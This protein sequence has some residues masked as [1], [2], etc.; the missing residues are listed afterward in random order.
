MDEPTPAIVRVHPCGSEPMPLHSVASSRAIERQGQASLPPHTLMRRAGEAV[1]RLALAV[2]PHAGTIWI[3]A[4]PGNNGGDG[5]EAARMLHLAGKRVAVS[6][7]ADPKQLP[8]DASDAL[9]RTQ[10]VGVPI[11]DGLPTRQEEALA[12]DALL[13]LGMRRP[14]EGVIAEAIA[15]LNAHQRPVL[16]VDVPSGLDCERGQPL[17]GLAVEADHTL[18]LL[19]LKPG[20]FTAQGRDHAGAVWLCDLGLNTAHTADAWLSAA[21]SWRQVAQVRRHA[22]HKGSF[23]DVVVIGGAEGMTGAA[24]LAAHAALIAGAGRV[25]VDPLAGG[26]AGPAPMPEL[27]CRL[28]ISDDAAALSRST[29]ACGCGG[30]TAVLTVLPAIL[31][32]SARLVLDADA[33]NAVASDAALRRLLRERSA[34]NLPSL[35][36]PHPLEAARLLGCDTATVQG[37]RVA[38]A[39]ELARRFACA[40]LL[41]GSGSVIAAPGEPPRINASGNALLATAGTGDVLAGWAAGAWSCKTEA[42]AHAV[43]AGTA[44][45]HGA[46]ADQAL[47]GST[48]IALNA[49]RLIGEMARAASLFA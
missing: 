3:A 36:T 6:L 31:E 27:M 7:L 42:T 25:Y 33:L 23:G 13:G 12:I 39:E 22:Q 5:L 32:H 35:L 34:R 14:A 8:S 49:S 19:T 4:G 29:V 44:W 10:Q 45:L 9:L 2:A 24:W 18:S 17:G 15:A 11:L 41:K 20:L 38:A 21:D 30:G 28:R 47:A 46:A 43:G 1:A 40:V 37:D 26:Q 48:R 16:A